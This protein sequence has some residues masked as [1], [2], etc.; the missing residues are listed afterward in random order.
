[1]NLGYSMEKKLNINS[2]RKLIF[3]REPSYG[4]YL[5]EVEE[6][7]SKNSKL[8]KGYSLSRWDDYAFVGYSSSRHHCVDFSFDVD[9]VL[10]FPLLH[11][12]GDDDELIVDDDDSLELNRRYM[13]IYKDDDLIKMEFNDDFDDEIKKFN[14]FVK[15][16]NYDGRSKIDCFKLDTKERLAKFFD[17]AIENIIEDDHQVTMEEYTTRNKVLIK[18]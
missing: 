14:V 13:R 1:M 6:G 12:L 9:H 4:T 10:Y 16:I 18:K 8:D 11:L 5:D 7:F 2:N 17:E 15:S 3:S